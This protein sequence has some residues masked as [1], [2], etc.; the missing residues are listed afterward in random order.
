MI[1]EWVEEYGEISCYG[2]EEF[3][4]DNVVIVCNVFVDEKC[5]CIIEIFK[6]CGIDY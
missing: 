4:V 2:V 6:Y 5:C 1:V 3:V